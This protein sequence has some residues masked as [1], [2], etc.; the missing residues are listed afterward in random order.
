M[1][2][3]VVV[4]RLWTRS[5]QKRDAAMVG[6]GAIGVAAIT[7][8]VGWDLA[9]TSSTD[10]PGA[11]RLLQLFTYQ[12][13][14]GWPASVDLHVA[15]AVFGAL[16]TLIAVAMGVRQIRR[17]ATAS[18]GALALAW[19]TWGLDV[20]MP[21]LAPH[22][23]QRD[24]IEAYYRDA[25]LAP[26]APLVA[27]QLNWKGENF[28]TGNHVAQFVSS[29]PTFTQW[30]RDQKGKGT[31]VMYVVTETNR[32]GGLKSELT[33]AVAGGAPPT[34]RELTTRTDSNQFILVR[35]EL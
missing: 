9:S 28:Y 14:R 12:Y 23:G 24:V 27:Y 33:S 20:Y 31:H 29:G 11:I 7:A 3:G 6:A 25:G 2:T 19:A 32:V 16:A 18:F 5:E 8:L 21:K 22:W 26:T 17:V 1:L 13:N 4:D 10:Q 15:L 34:F 30:I 35:A